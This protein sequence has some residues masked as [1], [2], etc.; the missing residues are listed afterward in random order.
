MEWVRSV[1]FAGVVACGRPAG[2]HVGI[3]EC[4]GD[5]CE[6]DAIGEVVAGFE[7]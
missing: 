1:T 7:A 4:V 6:D 2:C 3:F 5:V